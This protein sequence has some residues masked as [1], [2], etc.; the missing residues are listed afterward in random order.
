MNGI[1]ADGFGCSAVPQKSPFHCHPSNPVQSFSKLFLPA[2]GAVSPNRLGTNKKGLNGIRRIG[3]MNSGQAK[4][5]SFD[6][7]GNTKAFAVIPCNP[8]HPVQSFSLFHLSPVASQLTSPRSP[9]LDQRDV[10]RIIVARRRERRRI[11]RQR[12]LGH[13]QRDELA[14]RVRRHETDSR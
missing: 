10:R 13:M 12:P 8:S 9:L 7:I 1:A 6:K 4:D 14:C 3:R 11:V 5:F 2:F